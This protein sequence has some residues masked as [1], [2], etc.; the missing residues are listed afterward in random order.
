MDLENM[1]FGN[2]RG[3]FKVSRKLEGLF[4]AALKEAGF[5]EFGYCKTWKPDGPA[6][7][8]YNKNATATH[9]FVVQPYVDDNFEQA[10]ICPN[11]L[12]RTTGLKLRWYQFPL[13][14]SYANYDLSEEMLVPILER[15]VEECREHGATP[16]T[17][18]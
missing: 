18:K 15:F 7:T 12:D 2:S 1:L 4:L 3:D 6:P 16:Y 14:D 5:D 13:R 10:V 8:P 11:F 17:G 9:H